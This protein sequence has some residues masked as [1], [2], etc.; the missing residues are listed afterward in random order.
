MAVLNDEMTMRFWGTGHSDDPRRLG[1]RTMTESHKVRGII[2]RAVE[3][4]FIDFPNVGDGRTWPQHYKETAEC[5]TLATAVL[6]ALENS[7]YKI[8]PI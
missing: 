8:V 4:A 7:G 2:E 5:K 3:S 6:S 1:E